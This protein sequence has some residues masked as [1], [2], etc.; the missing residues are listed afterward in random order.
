MCMSTRWQMLIVLLCM[1]SGVAMIAQ[2]Y[3]NK[4][5]NVITVFDNIAFGVSEI[6]LALHYPFLVA[7]MNLCNR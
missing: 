1:S 7:L 3:V 4:T 5:S 2:V 6:R